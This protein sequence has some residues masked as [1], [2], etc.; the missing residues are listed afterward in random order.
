MKA[1]DK[2]KIDFFQN[3]EGSPSEEWSYIFNVIDRHQLDL[4]LLLSKLLE[5]R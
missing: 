5:K 1:I 4:A 2:G 3:L